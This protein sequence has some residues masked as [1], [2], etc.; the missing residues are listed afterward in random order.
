MDDNLCIAGLGDCTVNSRDTLRVHHGWQLWRLCHVGGAWQSARVVM[1]VDRH[2]PAVPTSKTLVASI[3]PQW[4]QLAARCIGKS[5][6]DHPKDWRCSKTAHLCCRT[7]QIESPLLIGQ[8]AH[9][10]RVKQTRS[11]QMVAAMKAK[12]TGDLCAFP[13]EDHGFHRPINSI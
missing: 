8:G 6:P 5:G 12:G 13:D 1:P 2:R 9:D 10:P 3:P 7:Q 11:D 4:K